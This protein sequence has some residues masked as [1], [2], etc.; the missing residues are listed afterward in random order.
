MKQE[1][2]ELQGFDNTL[3]PNTFLKQETSYHLAIIFPGLGYNADMPLLYYTTRVLKNKG[4]DVLQVRYN[5]QT[6]TF[7]SLTDE[8]QYRHII[9]DAI[10]VYITAREQ[11]HYSQVTLIGKSLGTL[12][13]GHLLTTRAELS[14]ATFIWLTPL[15]RNEE[16][17]K[18]IMALRHHALFAI[19]TKDPHYDSKVL[20]EIVQATDG[21]SLVFENA[22]HSLEVD[23][24]LESAQLVQQFVTKLTTFVA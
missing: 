24:V 5:Y 17:R 8:E 11:H 16:L 9:N 15:F 19:G 4:A 23:G 13:L 20:K 21:K 14:E 22:N 2:L 18:Q 6:K 12:A 3:I 1:M 10:T 7:Q